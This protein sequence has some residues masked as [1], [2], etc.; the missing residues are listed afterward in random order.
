ML[1]LAVK[2]LKKS[3][4]RL[5]PLVQKLHGKMTTI[6]TQ[7]IMRQLRSCLKVVCNKRLPIS[8]ST[9]ARLFKT[10]LQSNKKLNQNQLFR[11]LF[12]E[13]ILL[14]EEM[15]ID[16]FLKNLT[17]KTRMSKI[18]TGQRRLKFLTIQSVKDFIRCPSMMK[19]IR[20]NLLPNRNS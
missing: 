17:T 12:K 13:R 18:S 4:S 9:K 5:N 8:I 20:I 1:L 6:S 11:R 10:P 7:P 16:K 3:V 15:K 19:L 2:T 14:K